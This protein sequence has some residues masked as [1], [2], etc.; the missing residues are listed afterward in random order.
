M[1]R[2]FVWNRTRPDS[3]EP[4]LS[5][6][7]S[8]ASGG[9][10]RSK[11]CS[12]SPSMICIQCWI[13]PPK[14]CF[15]VL[16]SSKKTTTRWYQHCTELGSDSVAEVANFTSFAK[17]GATSEQSGVDERV[18]SITTLRMRPISPRDSPARWLIGHRAHR[19]QD[20]VV[21]RRL[22]CGH[23]HGVT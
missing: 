23:E 22:L 11:C 1:I 3:D 17:S 8:D 21:P 2:S 14:R 6:G 12:S 4:S 20:L 15:P 19:Y 7:T 10:S 13:Y 18:Q 9:R 16:A 5:M